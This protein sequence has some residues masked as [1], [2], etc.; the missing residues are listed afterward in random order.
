MELIA[1]EWMGKPMEFAQG[2][3]EADFA[4]ARKDWAQGFQMS[5]LSYKR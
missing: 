5:I 1:D 4:F 3:D 2:S